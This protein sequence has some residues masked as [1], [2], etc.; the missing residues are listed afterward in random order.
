[1]TKPGPVP[2]AFSLL[3]Q[4]PSMW[5]LGIRYAAIEEGVLPGK[6]WPVCRMRSRARLCCTPVQFDDGEELASIWDYDPPGDL[7]GSGAWNI[8]RE[9]ATTLNRYGACM[10]LLWQKPL[11]HSMSPA[12]L[13]LGRSTVYKIGHE[14][15]GAA[16]AQCE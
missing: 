14:V 6:R 7:A 3:H 2:L 10:D 15:A 8:L 11:L 12:S 5:K 1:M 16:C 4:A 9:L 13:R